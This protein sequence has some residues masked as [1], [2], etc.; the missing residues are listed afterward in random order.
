MSFTA[1]FLKI[2]CVN[3]RCSVINDN[4]TQES[5]HLFSRKGLFSR[6][7]TFISWLS[8]ILLSWR[9]PSII[10]EHLDYALFLILFFSIDA[11]Q[12]NKFDWR[13][14]TRKNYNYNFC[15]SR[16]IPI[17]GIYHFS[18][19]IPPTSFSQ[20]DCKRLAR[21]GIQLAFSSKADFEL[22]RL[23]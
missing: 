14:Q 6:N 8:D 11:F 9:I 21:L 5:F 19:Q 22:A 12:M 18:I 2:N 23:L 1:P 10:S 7:F 20:H 16:Y 3:K 15:V 4:A 17:D 13:F